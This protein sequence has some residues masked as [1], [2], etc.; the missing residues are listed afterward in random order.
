MIAFVIEFLTFKLLYHI[1]M[2]ILLLVAIFK[3]MLCSEE[4]IDRYKFIY[5]SF[6][7]LTVTYARKGDYSTL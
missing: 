2:W 6:G 7:I 4:P 1:K 5:H 3:L